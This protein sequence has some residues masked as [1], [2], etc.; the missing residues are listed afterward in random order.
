MIVHRLQD[1]P[2]RIEDELLKSEAL[3]ALLRCFVTCKANS[4]ENLLDPLLKIFRISTGIA[5]GMAK[6][7]FF[8]RITEKLSH[9]KAVVR[10]NLLRILRAVCDAHPNRAMLVERYGI[11]SMVAKLSKDDGAVLVRELAREIMPSLAPALKPS[12]SHRAIRGPDTPTGKVN[13]VGI[14]PKVRRAASE[15]L[16]ASPV[17]SSLGMSNVRLASRTRLANANLKS[18]PDISMSSQASNPSLRHRID[19]V[20]WHSPSPR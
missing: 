3:D 17:H 10:L 16:S 4:F 2:A 20:F 19:D 15:S 1:E 5:I 9:A 14:A 12:S 6:S 18:N 11:Y 7:Q 8:K 13:K